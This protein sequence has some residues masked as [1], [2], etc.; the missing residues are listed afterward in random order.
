MSL[1]SALNTAQSI[2]N[3]TGAQSSIVSNNISNAGNKDY[4]RRQAMLSTSLGG[5]QVVKISRAQEDALLKQY[6]KAASQDSAQQTLLGGLED[7]KSIMGGNDNET[8]PE[9][10]LRTFRDKLGTFRA[11]PG[12]L[13]AAQG[14]I[15]AAQDVVTS[16][17]N[18][19]KAVQQQRADADKQIK[20][21]VD[22]LNSLLRQFETANNAVK[23]AT[24]G[25]EDPSSALD[26]REK[27]LK[28]IS[29]IVGVSTVQ[30]PNNDMALY[31]AD[32]TTLF[33]TIPRS[34]SFEPTQSYAASTVGNKV[35]IDG[36]AV[37]MGSGSTT[38]AQGSM[39][40]LLQIRDDIAPT[41]QSQL[42]EV[43][44]G[45]V[46]LYQEDGNPG[47]F[48]WTQAN[49][50]AGGVPPAGTVIDGIAGTIAIN[51]RVVTSKGGDPMRLRDGNINAA[52]TPANPTGSSGYTAELDRLYTAMDSGI[53]FDPTTGLDSNVSILTY[54]TN[55]LG[56]LE[57]N[58][59]NA[60]TAAEN[61]SAA[62][63]RTDE[64][65]SNET[66]VNLDEELTLLL[67][68]EQSYKA[69]TKILNAVDEMLKALL[70]I[71]S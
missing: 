37:N 64:A 60:T 63:A 6:L 41:F 36:V 26:E 51:D 11:T 42:D 56:W 66:G 52:S 27:V 31:T 45:L 4:V 1:T 29:Q 20:N 9:T 3:N 24:A 17:N 65:Y 7:L 67:D 47:L 71:A 35:Y 62:A 19:S 25:N 57:Q 49:G 28:Q 53:A 33:E 21:Q 34:V 30:R 15:T 54:A 14:A 32:G 22:S 10:A 12:D 40:S 46:N 68:I 48:V 58:R 2:F 8:S 16:L 13:I 43:A 59:S 61:T 18:A 70:D 55:S 69:A 50:T 39:A 38:N 5:A 44:R 23:K